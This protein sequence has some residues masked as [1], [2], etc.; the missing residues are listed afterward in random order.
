MPDAF[1]GEKENDLDAK[2]DAGQFDARFHA[3]GVEV[4]DQHREE[5]GKGFPTDALHK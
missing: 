4:C 5:E 3:S 2:T 1:M